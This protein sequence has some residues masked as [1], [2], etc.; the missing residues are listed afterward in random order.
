L[1]ILG[2]VVEEEKIFVNIGVFRVFRKTKVDKA[3]KRHAH[4]QLL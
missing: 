1:E 3:E 4:H 2:K